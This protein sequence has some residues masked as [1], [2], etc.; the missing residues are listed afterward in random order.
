MKWTPCTWWCWQEEVLVRSK[1]REII[2]LSWSGVE[3]LTRW[4]L[5]WL[6]GW[7]QYGIHKEGFLQLKKQVPSSS[8]SSAVWRPK[9]G[10][11]KNELSCAGAVTV[12]DRIYSTKLNLMLL[13]I[14]LPSFRHRRLY[15]F[16]LGGTSAHLLLTGCCC[17]CRWCCYWKKWET[18]TPCLVRKVKE[19]LLL[20]TNL[21][22]SP[23][24]FIL[25]WDYWDATAAATAAAAAD[26]ELK[27]VKF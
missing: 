27:C 22:C 23:S 21:C 7:L 12:V 9:H 2:Y 11:M 6:V 15:P 26:D 13:T 14:P 18:T 24:L 8:S 5:G 16:L 17:C 4:L 19:T 10:G 20:R 25:L 1:R 3:W